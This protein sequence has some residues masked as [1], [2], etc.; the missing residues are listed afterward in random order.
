MI[1]ICVFDLLSFMDVLFICGGP[2]RIA[3]YL[4]TKSAF[5]LLY[6]LFNKKY[7]VKEKI[8]KS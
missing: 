3:V 4:E 7:V 8:G 2:N 1:F 6:I 5:M